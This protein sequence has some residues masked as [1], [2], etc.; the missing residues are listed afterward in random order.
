[1][2]SAGLQGSRCSTE[3]VKYVCTGVVQGCKGAGIV[4]AWYRGAGVVK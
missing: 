3:V 2:G 1:M 4:C